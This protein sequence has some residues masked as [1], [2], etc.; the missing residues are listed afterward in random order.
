[1]LTGIWPFQGKTSIDVRHAV[2]HD[3]PLPLDQ[4]R[5]GRTPARLQA[6][7]DRTLAKDPKDRYQKAARSARRLARSAAS[8]SKSERSGSFSEP[9][10]PIAP[11]HL[12][13]TG[14]LAARCAGCGEV[15]GRTHFRIALRRLPSDRCTKRR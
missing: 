11:R 13:G 2:L 7:L 8:K 4:A 9:I 14:P 12:A 10:A 1:M 6:I 5:P 3:D 15:P